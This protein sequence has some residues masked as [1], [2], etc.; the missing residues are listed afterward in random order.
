MKAQLREIYLAGFN[1]EMSQ[2]MAD[3]D[4]AYQACRE[5]PEKSPED[6][7]MVVTEWSKGPIK[8]VWDDFTWSSIDDL[9]AHCGYFIYED[10]VPEELITEEVIQELGPILAVLTLRDEYAEEDEEEQEEPE[11]VVIHKV[12][13]EGKLNVEYTSLEEAMTHYSDDST[14]FLNPKDGEFYLYSIYGESIEC[15][16]TD[17]EEMVRVDPVP[18]KASFRIMED[19]IDDIDNRVLSDQL[20]N[21]INGRKPFRKFKDVLNNYPQDRKAWFAFQRDAVLRYGLKALESEGLDVALVTIDAFESDDSGDN[22]V[23]FK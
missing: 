18:S 13:Q 22:V 15:E 6:L 23:P 3:F 10:R 4:K 20:A 2:T 12:R 7:A 21:A 14:W 8:K 17:F 1:K 9:R 5:N 11:A 19:F 16:D